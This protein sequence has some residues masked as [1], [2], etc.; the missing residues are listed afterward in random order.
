MP[1]TIS[2]PPSAVSAASSPPSRPVPC[3]PLQPPSSRLDPV[4]RAILLFKSS[5]TF[6]A[7]GP[8]LGAVC[9]FFPLSPDRW[10]PLLYVLLFALLAV[11]VLERWGRQTLAAAQIAVIL[12]AFLLGAV[13]LGLLPRY[14][15]LQT[16]LPA[17][18]ISI[19]DAALHRSSSVFLFHDAWAFWDHRSPPQTT[20][21]YRRKRSP[22][23]FSWTL[24]L[25]VPVAGETWT[26]T[27]PVEVWSL[28]ESPR[29]SKPPTPRDLQTFVAGCK[30][31]LLRG[32]RTTERPPFLG[33]LAASRPAALD[34]RQGTSPS[35][36][37]FQDAL[38]A[39]YRSHRIA[40]ASNAI[41]AAQRQ[42]KLSSRPFALWLFPTPDIHAVLQTSKRDLFA[43]AL[44]FPAAA[45]LLLSLL[46]GL[47][48]WYRIRIAP[49][50]WTT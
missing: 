22:K 20:A 42:H 15:L 10:L 39:R 34:L 26:P 8:L 29:Q 11:V 44:F 2:K 33:D 40:G 14:R 50:R 24:S 3:P 25:A 23:P 13:V 7:G 47:W 48:A 1:A 5:L 43:V 41:Q 30:D 6:F 36:F 32:A 9:S 31:E 19:R 21:F 37:P 12:A 28:C 18:G 16:P 4:E 45:F 17:V 38:H 49:L 27:S 46:A 35:I